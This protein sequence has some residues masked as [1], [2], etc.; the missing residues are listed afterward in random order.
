MLV[1]DRRKFVSSLITLDEEVA[2]RFAEDNGVEGELH[3][4]PEVVS[5]S[6]QEVDE[7]V[8]AQFARVEQVR[9]FTVLPRN[10]TIEDGELTATLKLKRQIVYEN[11]VQEI[12]KI[13][14][15]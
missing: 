13:Y 12:D 9:K 14:A 3:T 6:Q 8:N 11:W 1:A 2:T 5:A 4:H 10:F 7:K 15:E